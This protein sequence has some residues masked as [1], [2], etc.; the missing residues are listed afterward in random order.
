[1]EEYKLVPFCGGF[2]KKINKVDTSITQV[3][4][5]NSPEIKYENTNT[6]N[7][8]VIHWFVKNRT[9]LT[10]T[11]MEQFHIN[12]IKSYNFNDIF[13][14][15]IICLG[16]DDTNNNTL[17]DFI[18]SILKDIIPNPIFVIIQN[19]RIL[20]EFNTYYNYVFKQLKSDKKIFYMHFKGVSKEDNFHRFQAEKIWCENLYKGCFAKKVLY[21]KDKF[22]L[23]GSHLECKDRTWFQRWL[24]LNSE[25]LY[26]HK[27]PFF[28][29]MNTS[30]LFLD[31][32]FQWVNTKNMREYIEKFCNIDEFLNINF[33]LYNIRYTHF[34]E[35]FLCSILVKNKMLAN[36]DN[37]IRT[38]VLR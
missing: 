6:N 36:F 35:Y 16:I 37:Q 7:T 29:N 1:M 25:T 3:I 17:I 10:L 4:N 19:D 32:T 22:C 12:H 18:K 30:T 14:N 34:S 23:S 21:N 2:I 24:W 33:K 11:Q 9:N 27:Y 31:G 26:T 15:S 38:N 8:L 20:G 28:K 5:T 13:T